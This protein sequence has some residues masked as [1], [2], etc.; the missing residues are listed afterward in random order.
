MSDNSLELHV[1]TTADS[2]AL[3][4]VKETIAQVKKEQ[5]AETRAAEKAADATGALADKKAELKDLLKGLQN[6]FPALAAVGRLALNPIALATAGI[7]AGW[8]LWKT[9]I[10]QATAAL[11]N[12][13]LP[14]SKALDPGHISAMTTEWENYTKAVSGASDKRNSLGADIL[15][16]LET[17][18]EQTELYKEV[19]TAEENAELARIKSEQAKGAGNGGL[20]KAQAIAETLE[21]KDRSAEAK[22]NAQIEYE[23]RKMAEQRAH[24]E[25]LA[26]EAEWKR[27]QASK[28][29]LASGHDDD[30]TEA[31]MA[32]MAQAAKKGIAENREWI[33]KLVDYQA[34]P[35]WKRW[36][37]P[38][39]WTGS[40]MLRYGDST[41]EEALDQERQ[42]LA[43]NQLSATR[44]RERRKQRPMRDNFRD[45]RSDLFKEAAEEQSASD[46]FFENE[47]DMRQRWDSRK[48]AMLKTT[49]LGAQQ[50]VYEAVAEVEREIAEGTRAVAEQIKSSGRAQAKMLKDLAELQKLSGDLERELGDLKFQVYQQGQ[51]SSH[52]R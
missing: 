44:L 26:K 16:T 9:R 27:G 18:K 5:E 46:E 29:R 17:L 28:I 52:Q 49:T 36:L 42:S 21:T 38:M 50:R 11:A 15:K 13:E 7:A 51:R 35:K 8:G 40:M 25:R 3:H 33:G 34:L 1:K 4:T 14:P 30:M 10:E 12:V 48:A 22:V 2:Q 41:V 45:F 32:E 43:T 37:S 39:A 19:T 47:P 20:T 23:E 24:A 31:E 6:E